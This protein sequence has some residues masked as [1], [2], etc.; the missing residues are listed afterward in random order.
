[1]SQLNRHLGLLARSV[2][3]AFI[4]CDLAPGWVSADQLEKVNSGSL[5]EVDKA[6]GKGRGGRAYQFIVEIELGDSATG[7]EVD[8]DGLFPDDKANREGENFKFGALRRNRNRR[9][10]DNQECQGSG[11]DH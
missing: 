5:P 7:S 1:M 8:L 10:S 6:A 9:K 2:D 3:P 11:H 4:A